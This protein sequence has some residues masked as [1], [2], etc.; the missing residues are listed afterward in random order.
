[1][2]SQ[3]TPSEILQFL[4]WF[5]ELPYTHKVLVA[6]NHDWLFERDPAAALSLLANYP[7]ITYLNDSGATIEGIRFWGSPVQPTFMNWAFNRDP[8]EIRQ[9]WDRIPDGIDVLVT[10]GPPAGIL[11]TIE[12]HRPG[13]GCPLLR[14]A[15]SRVK[16]RLHVFGHIHE[17]R[18]I[19]QVEETLYVNA[20]VLNGKYRLY[21]HDQIEVDL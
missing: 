7:S 15:V 17:G 18:G 4:E 16:P 1:M 5:S 12:N 14:A 10:H 19:R 3:G 6:G 9:H 13:A 2:S 21:E 11:D 8:A 20:A